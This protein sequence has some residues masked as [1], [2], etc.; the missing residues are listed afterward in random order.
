MKD[1]AFSLL[2][3]LTEAHGPPGHEDGPR[4]VFARELAPLGP[5]STDRLGSVLC[6]VGAATGPRSGP[7]LMVTAHLDEVGFMV[8]S[9]TDTG[10]L[11]LVPLGGWWTHTLLAQR[12]R[13]R[14]RTGREHL[15]IVTSTPPH[16][17]A[18]AEKSKVLAMEQL[19]VDVGASSRRHAEETLGLRPGDVAVPDSSCTPLSDPDL[20]CAKAFDNR[21]GVAVTITALQQLAAASYPAP[22]QLLGVATVQEEVGCRGAETAAVL[23]RPDVALVIEGTPADDTPGHPASARQAVLGQ[24]PQ[25]RVMDPTALMNPRLVQFI[26]DVATEKNIPYQLAVR[27]SGGTDA[28]SFSTSGLGVASVVIGVPARYI[29]THNSVIHLDDYLATV[30]LVVEVVRR[31]DA[32][33]VEG[34]TSFLE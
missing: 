21:V 31:L 19:F 5:L 24:G 25:I 22:G 17:L 26:A 3:E 6:E 10:F 32:G 13:I 7:R 8:H 11:T 4:A 20:L 18:E 12:L 28:R 27:R 34:L 9:I 23:A 33:T 16:F 30:A 15:G 1:A 14:T 2:R 29:H